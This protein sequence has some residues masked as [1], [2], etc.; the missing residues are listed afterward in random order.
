MS[1]KNILLEDDKVSILTHVYPHKPL[2]NVF[3]QTYMH[4]SHVFGNIV[5]TKQ[6]RGLFTVV[7]LFVTNAYT[8][9]QT[10]RKTPQNLQCGYSLLTFVARSRIG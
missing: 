10:L 3:F 5:Q 9:K 4:I 1:L 2:R 7:V 8:E 6:K